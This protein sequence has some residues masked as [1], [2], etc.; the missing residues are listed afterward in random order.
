MKLAKTGRKGSA[1]LV[2][3][4]IAKS[5]RLGQVS[6]L[7][8]ALEQAQA[9]VADKP[10]AAKSHQTLAQALGAVHRFADAREALAKAAELG[11]SDNELRQQ[12]GVLTMALGRYD[13]AYALLHEQRKKYSNTVTW[14]L[15]GSVLGRMGRHEE[16]DAAFAEAEK[17]YT[18]ASPFVVSWLL[19]ERASMWDRA[20]EVEQAIRYYRLSLEALPQHAHA[21]GHLAALLPP[22]EAIPL[23]EG[24]L[25]SS[26]DP[27]YRAMLGQLKNEQKA[28][29]GD[30]LVAEAAKGY[31]ELMAAAPL[32]FSD[33]AGWFYL[34]VAG[35]PGRAVEVAEKNLDNRK[36][37]EGYELLLAA[38]LA[39]KETDEACRI[40]DLA[41]AFKYPTPGMR[42]MAARAFESC[43]REGE[44]AKLR[45]AAKETRAKH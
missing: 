11:S 3:I 27:E 28:G 21:A 6:F 41:V 15:E 29:S 25:K 33:H 31:D 13:E 40:A 34:D 9:V 8:K 22:S 19:F 26:D 32:A 37:P 14:A 44:G 23:L 16:A 30:D 24:I 18:K 12:R 45:A 17:L 35:K 10:K 36:V 20:G 7:P 5:S 1:D 42:R 4:Y 38:L 2:A 39:A 43:G